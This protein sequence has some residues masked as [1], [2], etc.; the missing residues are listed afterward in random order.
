MVD[1]WSFVYLAEDQRWLRVMYGPFGVASAVMI[2]LTDVAPAPISNSLV[3]YQTGRSSLQPVCS[4]LHVSNKLF[5]VERSSVARLSRCEDLTI[6]PRPSIL[7]LDLLKRKRM[8][9]PQEV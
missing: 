9:H 5:A 8:N 2:S 4:S 1:D 3:G 7:S 6:S